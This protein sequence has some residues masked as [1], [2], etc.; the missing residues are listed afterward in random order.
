MAL[1]AGAGSGAGA[2]ETEFALPEASGDALE[3]EL[4]IEP[5]SA[6]ACGL[7]VRCSPDGAE[8][9][10]IAAERALEIEFGKASLRDDLAFARW[11]ARLARPVQSAPLQFDPAQPVTLRVFVD[12]SVVEVFAGAGAGDLQFERYLAQRIY[13]TRPD[14]LGVKLFSRGGSSLARRLRTWQMH[15]V[16]PQAILRKEPRRQGGLRDGDGGH[17]WVS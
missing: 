14:A 2:A 3:I 7:K 4:Q 16:R 6:A 8:E 11:D 5:G 13:P 12:H 17:P 10:A 15:A 1:A 9:T